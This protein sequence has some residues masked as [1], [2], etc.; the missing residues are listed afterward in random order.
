MNAIFHDLVAATQL[1]NQTLQLLGHRQNCRWRALRRDVKFFW[2]IP[3]ETVV[4]QFTSVV[5]EH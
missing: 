5:V 3:A 4:K 1:T 2:T